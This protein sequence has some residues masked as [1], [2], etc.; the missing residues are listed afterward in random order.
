VGFEQGCVVRMEGWEGCWAYLQVDL[1]STVGGGDQT[2]HDGGYFGLFRTA[3]VCAQEEGVFIVVVR[4]SV[5]CHCA[6]SGR[7]G[8]ENE[9]RD[10]RRL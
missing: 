8:I 4:G 1:V 10:K 3:V 5:V 6:R 7:D 9:R 2:P